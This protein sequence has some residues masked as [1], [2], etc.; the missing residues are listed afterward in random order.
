MHSSMTLSTQRHTIT[1]SGIGITPRLKVMQFQFGRLEQAVTRPAAQF[2]MGNRSMSGKLG[3]N[4]LV[5]EGELAIVFEI[6]Y[7]NTSGITMPCYFAERVDEVGIGR[8]SSPMK[9]VNKLLRNLR[10]T[11]VE[12]YIRIKDYQQ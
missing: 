11:S 12:Q 10:I 9:A 5:S 7:D 3:V 4:T 1:D 8:G 6:V 2:L